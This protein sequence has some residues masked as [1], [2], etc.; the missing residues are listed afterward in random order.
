MG[1]VTRIEMLTDHCTVRYGQRHA[2]VCGDASAF[3]MLRRDKAAHAGD[4]GITTAPSD[5][6]DLVRQ[7][8]LEP[9]Y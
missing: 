6:S 1:H 5:L 7:A 2:G 8:W 3:A 9:A 4:L